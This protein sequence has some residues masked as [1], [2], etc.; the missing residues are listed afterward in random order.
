MSHQIP[1]ALENDLPNELA[2]ELA[3]RSESSI[4]FADD[5]EF[6]NDNFAPGL[7]RGEPKHN[8]SYLFSVIK[9]GYAMKAARISNP[10]YR[11]FSDLF[12]KRHSRKHRSRAKFR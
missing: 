1:T 6:V 7:I 9:I 3:N 8:D 4:A 12:R 2:V 10:K 11:S 5:P